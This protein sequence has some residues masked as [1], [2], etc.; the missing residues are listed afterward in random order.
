MKYN[1]KEGDIVLYISQTR[2]EAGRVTMIIR[3][4]DHFRIVPLEKGHHVK[5]RK[6][7]E[8]LPL[9]KVIELSKQFG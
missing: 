1:I 6:E 4:K 5:K 2:V 8:L 3:E 7:S 9:K